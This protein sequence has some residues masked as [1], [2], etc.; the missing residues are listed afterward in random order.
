MSEDKIVALTGT[1]PEK[2]VD[3][4]DRMLREFNITVKTNVTKKAK[5]LIVGDKPSSS[6]IKKAE[7]YEIPIVD[8]Y[9]F[10]KHLAKS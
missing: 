2:R 8:Y 6:K 7:D 10:I 4:T 1:L 9:A 3:F 5:C